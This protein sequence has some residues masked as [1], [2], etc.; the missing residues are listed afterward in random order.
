MTNEV[1]LILGSNLGNKE[2]F[3]EKALQEIELNVGT[4]LKKSKVIETEPWGFNSK[5]TFLNQAVQI[6]TSLSPISLLNQ[7]QKI[8]ISLGRLHKT[9]NSY[10]DRTIDIDIVTYNSIRFFSKRLILPHNLH[11]NEREFSKLLLEDIKNF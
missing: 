9:I 11:L 10:Q 2:F 8:E 4:V 3:L 7:L 5:N 6:K 1:I